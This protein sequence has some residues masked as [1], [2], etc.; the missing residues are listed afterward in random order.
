LRG[1]LGIILIN[2]CVIFQN[3]NEEMENEKRRAILNGKL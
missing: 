1:D 2:F 3:K